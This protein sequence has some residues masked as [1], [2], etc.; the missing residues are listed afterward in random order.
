MRQVKHAMARGA[1]R[2][3][4]IGCGTR[5]CDMSAGEIM[6]LGM[7]SAGTVKRGGSHAERVPHDLKNYIFAMKMP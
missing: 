6:H 3:K 5:H 7:D 4:A 2:K 1:A